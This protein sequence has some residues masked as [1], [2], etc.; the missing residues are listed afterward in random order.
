MRN[1]RLVNTCTILPLTNLVRFT[2]LFLT[3]LMSTYAGVAHTQDISDAP[4]SV[5]S[6]V[7][8][9]LIL[10]IDDSGSMAWGYII[11]DYNSDDQDLAAYRAASFNELAYDPNTVY[12]PPLNPDG[13]SHDDADFT[14]AIG[15]YYHPSS[16]QIRVNLSTSYRAPRDFEIYN[17]YFADSWDCPTTICSAQAAYYY[18]Y[19]GTNSGCS[20]TDDAKRRDNDCYDKITVASDEQQNFANWFQYYSTREAA[21]KSALLRVLTEDN[22]SGSLRVARQSFNDYTTVSSGNGSN[23]LAILGKNNERENLYNWIQGLDPSGGTPARPAAVRAGE[24][25]K[26]ADAYREDPADS[27]S[28]ISSCRANTH[29]LVTDGAYNGYDSSVSALARH[30][31]ASFTLPD[32]KSYSPGSENQ[33]IFQNSHDNKSLADIAFHYWAT[34]LYGNSTDDKVKPF[35]EV[36]P[37]D[38]DAPT[39]QEYWNASNDPAVWQHMTT[40]TVAF[41]LSGTIPVPDAGVYT[42]L[43]Q[44]TYKNDDGGDGWPNPN[45]DASKADD[46]YHAGINGRGGFYTASDPNTLVGSFSRILDNISARQASAST[47]VADSGRISSNTLLYVA[48]YNTDE[49]TGKLTAYNVSDGSKFDPDATS[50]GSD[51]NENP[52]GTLCDEEWD[53]GVINTETS[54]PHVSRNIFTY[55]STASSGDEPSGTGI[56]FKFDQLNDDQKS[57]LSTIATT[58]GG[59]GSE[60]CPVLDESHWSHDDCVDYSYNCLSVLTELPCDGLVDPVCYQAD[61]NPNNWPDIWGWSAYNWC[62]SWGWFCEYAPIEEIDCPESSSGGASAGNSEDVVNYIR[63]DSSKEEQNGGSFRTRTQTRLGPIFHSSPV[64]VGDGKD[65]N[66]L[67]QFD[68]PDDLESSAYSSFISSIEGRPSMVYVGANDGMLHAYNAARG[69]GNELF[70]YIPNAVI[71]ELN[72]LTDPTFNSNAYVDGPIKVQDAFFN[73]SWG[74]MLVGGLRSGAQAYYALDITD[75]ESAVDADGAEDL[76]LWEF[77]DKNDSDMGYSTGAAQIVRSNTGKWIVLIGNGHF[78]EESDDY[79]GTGKAILFAL[80][81]ATGE[82]IAKIDVGV[83]NASDPNGLSTPTGILADDEDYNVDYAYAGDLQ[84]NMWRFDLSS[85]NPNDW[86]ASLL[87]KTDSGQPITGAPTIGS[88]PNGAEGFIVYFGTGRYLG[89]SDLPDTTEQALY[90]ILD[91]LNCTSSSSAC[92]SKSNLLEQSIETSFSG[93]S[94]VTGNQ[95]DWSTHKGWYMNLVSG[96]GER[97]AGQP[98]LIGPAIVF[99]SIVPKLDACDDGG[100]NNLYVLN[101]GNGGTTLKQLIDTDKDGTVDED[102]KGTKSDDE[103]EIISIL[104]PDNEDP[105]TELKFFAD[106]GEENAGGGCSEAVAAGI[107]MTCF[108]SGARTN[109]IRWRQLQ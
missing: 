5:G 98:Q 96:S 64:Y 109:R 53:A 52:L 91:E 9:N 80:D 31:N 100:Y 65:A 70:S 20:G 49:W 79:T 71:G 8:P 88:H 107:N 54:L 72:D 97:V 60:L 87:Y 46:T 50:S 62:N 103:Q 66:K 30:D 73:G 13:S 4:L 29:I 28:E 92:V 81:A 23:K 2:F 76:V 38:P 36:D 78:S 63:G 89:E 40:Y 35:Y 59:S 55:S 22:V 15:G 26:L 45:D 1:E 57:L 3:L 90:G 68:F 21:A 94:S 99:L 14:S 61:S 27:T 44:G 12:Q 69:G 58:G 17:K 51:C 108:K 11:S 41:G 24:F 7:A 101:R 37:V 74:T 95:I 19:D 25:Y 86:G 102:D 47:V 93:G 104:R 34:D 75:P 48:S 106:I 84:G 18:V 39:E 82:V 6:N 43:L 105:V 67:Q 32:G 10:T 56:E 77:S 85:S 33:R 42:Q 16:Y 83:G